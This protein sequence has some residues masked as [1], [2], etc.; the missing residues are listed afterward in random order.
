ML[1]AR[2]VSVAVLEAQPAPSRKFGEV[3][4]PESAP[5]VAKL[6]LDRALASSPHVARRC[7]GVVR[8]W[9]GDGMIARRLYRG[10]AGWIV[11][12]SHFEAMLACG[13][14]RCGARWFAAHR[15][16]EVRRTSGGWRISG[17]SAHGDFAV[18]CRFV[19]DATGRAAVVARR[20]G[21]RL[22][23][24][25]RLVAMTAR[26]TATRQ[27]LPSRW[28]T[29]EAALDGWWYAIGLPDGSVHLA[30]HARPRIRRLPR[31]STEFVASL[32][33]TRLVGPRVAC[34]AADAL[35]SGN[36][37]LE[38]IDATPGRLTCAAGDG[39]IAVGDAAA[40]FDPL[41]SQGLP[42]ALSTGFYAA[43]AV[44]ESLAGNPEGCA[45]F[46]KA[47][48]LTHAATSFG[49]RAEYARAELT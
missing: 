37:A 19:A 7:A 12:R 38:L 18:R 39:W 36:I 13:A 43:H 6:G 33:Q 20:L 8:S 21:A 47:V 25:A 17:T 3:L 46:A 4:A 29:I 44:Y 9:E 16:R 27:R 10:G 45:A 31:T 23:R 35:R 5:I 28:L 14:E 32:A 2:G 41:S 30:L 11:D 26:L 34:D 48:A 42:N 22:C 15:V 24:E 49:L 1:V 40:S